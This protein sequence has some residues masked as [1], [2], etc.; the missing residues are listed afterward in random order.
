MATGLGR[1]FVRANVHLSQATSRALRLPTDK[2]FWQTFERRVDEQIRALPDGST[3]IDVGGGRRCVY[4][5]ALRPEIS[6]VAVDISEEELALN[7]HARQTIVA[8]VSHELPLPRGS[9]DLV[10]SRAV[11]E[12]V[13]DVPAAARNIAGV[14]KPGGR[15]LHFLPGRY[16]LFAIAA[17]IMPFKL[18]LRLLHIALPETADQVEFEVHYDRGTPR[19]IAKAFR[20]A[21]FREVSVEVTWAQPGYFEPVYPAFLLYAIYEAVVRRMRVRRLAA[22]M[23]V[24]AKR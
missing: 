17:R 7:E 21:G 5:H 6:L 11:L 22:Y 24:D 23:I 19:G 20:D 8:D 13:S 10:V 2:T 18:L 4:Y 3:V 1:R 15:T 14:V 9:V 16:S 12:H